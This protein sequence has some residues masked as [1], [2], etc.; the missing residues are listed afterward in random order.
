VFWMQ[1]VEAKTQIGARPVN[2]IVEALG[3]QE[4]RKLT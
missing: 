3:E 2:R 4:G 1:D